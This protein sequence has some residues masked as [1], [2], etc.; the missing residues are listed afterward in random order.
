MHDSLWTITVRLVWGNGI[1]KSTF[2]SAQEPDYT[3]EGN[4][5]RFFEQETRRLRTF[6]G[7]RYHY[8]VVGPPQPFAK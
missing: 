8:E 1:E 2:Y 5:I 6:A 7:E 3:Y 4:E